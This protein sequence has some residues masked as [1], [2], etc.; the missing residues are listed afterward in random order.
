MT[1]LTDRK[2]RFICRH[3]VD[4]K[5]WTSKKISKLYNISQ[6]RI[7][8]LVKFYKETGKFPVLEKNRR[9]KAKPLTK[10]EKDIIEE[11]WE[12]NHFGA[13]LLYRELKLRGYK[14][15]H[16]KLHNYLTRTGKSIPNPNKQK[17]RKR[18]RY[19]RKHSFSLVHGDWHRTTE[20]DPY[21]I[22]WLDDASRF[23]L[24][25]CEFS[26]ATA[27]HSIDTFQDA[28]NKANEYNSLIHSV[29]TDRGA[30]FYSN[31]P[32]SKSRFELFLDENKIKYLP[33]RRNNPQTNGK[34]E[35]LWLEYNRHRWRFETIQ[36]FIDW[37]NKR[38]HG[39]LW[40]EIGESPKE[41]VW[42]KNRPE[43]MLGLF[44]RGVE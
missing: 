13:R 7:Q 8:Q 19:E 26:E 32:N 4:N 12:E 15:P 34:L 14:I 27:E 31:H 39:A 29:N 38:M 35:R 20:N 43:C 25:G 9:P 17:K 5:D 23:I 10:E 30:Q 42:R 6:R 18:C 41:A 3:I 37:Y 28:M 2:I 36:E 21:A 44:W 24:A 33:S 40:M 11:I 1:K 16:H 22:I